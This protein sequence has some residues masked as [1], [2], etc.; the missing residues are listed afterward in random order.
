MKKN[1]ITI[2][3]AGFGVCALLAGCGE[4]HQAPP[5]ERNQ[6]VNRFF[7]SMETGNSVSATSQGQKLLAMDPGNDYIAKLV[8]AGDV[9]GALAV[10]EEGLKV[11]P[12]N[13][14]L[15][16][17]RGQLRQL[18]HAKMLI[19][20]MRSAK[21]SSA[22]TA[23]LTAATTGLSSNRT[24]KL[25]N[26]FKTYRQRIAE[27]AAREQAAAVAEPVVPARPAER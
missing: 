8:N 1:F 15:S 21:S 23:A 12:L 11:Y 25:E 4:E 22:M 2:I 20:N 14:T 10:V 18:R 3:S 19:A 17:L 27:T 9:A 5:S 13:R 7:R 26:Y 24:E 6:L 16:Q